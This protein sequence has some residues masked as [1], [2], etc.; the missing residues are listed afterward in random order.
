[1]KGDITSDALD[2]KRI[3]KECYEQISAHKF[4]NLDEM[5]Q[6]PKRYNLPKHTRIGNLNKPLSIKSNKYLITFQNRE[7]QA[8]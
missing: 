1:M 5:D 7:H 6:L 2:I 8:Q 3:V 4:G